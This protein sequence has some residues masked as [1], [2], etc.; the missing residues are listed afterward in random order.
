M[1]ARTEKPQTDRIQECIAILSKLQHDL[2]IPADNISIRVLKKRM[3][4]YWRDGAYCEDRIPLVGSDR[5]ILYKF[6]R[7]SHQIVEITLRKARITFHS[8]P[9]DL[10]AEDSQ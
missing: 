5:Y 8:A 3:A 4:K 10:L 6:P 2:E 9:S 7:W 1:A